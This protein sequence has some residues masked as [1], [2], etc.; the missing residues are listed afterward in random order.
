[1]Q[2]VW[3]KDGAILNQCIFLLVK[4]SSK[5]KVQPLGLS[6]FSPKNLANAIFWTEIPNNQPISE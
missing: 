2:L 3:P 5:E 4:L 1:M 6:L